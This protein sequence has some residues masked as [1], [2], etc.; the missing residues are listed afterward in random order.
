MTVHELERMFP[1]RHF[2]PDGHMVGIHQCCI[3]RETDTMESH[4]PVI[5]L[6]FHIKT[7][8]IA[9]CTI[10]NIESLNQTNEKDTRD[11]YGVA[12]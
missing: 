8:D 11:F 5:F 2:T 4:I 6:A 10:R 9:S 1:G 3:R 12:C 7:F